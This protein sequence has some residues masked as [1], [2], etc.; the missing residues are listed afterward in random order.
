MV[1]TH[2]NFSDD[3]LTYTIRGYLKMYNVRPIPVIRVLA[4]NKEIVSLSIASKVQVW[5]KVLVSLVRDPGKW[6]TIKWRKPQIQREDMLDDDKKLWVVI[7]VS[8]INYVQSEHGGKVMYTVDL[9]NLTY[10]HFLSANSAQ[11][12]SAGELFGTPC[13]VLSCHALDNTPVL[14]ITD[15]YVSKSPTRGITSTQVNYIYGDDSIIEEEL[16][17]DVVAQ[18]IWTSLSDNVRV[19]IIIYKDIS[20]TALKQDAPPTGTAPSAPR[21]II[22]YDPP[23]LSTRENNSTEITCVH[24][25]D[26]ITVPSTVTDS[27]NTFD[28]DS[29]DKELSFFDAL[30]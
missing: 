29:D 19:M 26:S 30:D 10:A 1:N 28:H 17:D 22:Q 24:S 6:S 21:G 4:D 27:Y 5:N 23:L 3:D 12:S 16:L 15:K 8:F 18:K 11:S 2:T 14:P 13:Y 25:D 7:V 9:S 20:G